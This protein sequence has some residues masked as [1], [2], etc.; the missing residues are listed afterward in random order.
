[1]AAAKP[2]DAAPSI[3]HGGRLAS[4]HHRTV[5]RAL[6]HAKQQLLG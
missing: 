5:A 6:I 2:V 3:R 4:L 1:M